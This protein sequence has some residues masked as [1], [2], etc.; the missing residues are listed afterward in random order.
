MRL[1]PPQVHRKLLAMKV[2][3]LATDSALLAAL[4][5]AARKHKD[6]RRK[7]VAASPYINHPIAVAALLGRMGV[8]DIA[9]LPGRS[10][11]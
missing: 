2:Q 6:Q 7:D 10:V 8:S 5:F 11:A 9:A 4:D 3:I 1:R